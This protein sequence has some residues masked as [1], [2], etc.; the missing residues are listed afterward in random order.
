MKIEQDGD[1]WVV[2]DWCMTPHGWLYAG[3]EWFS[4]KQAAIEFINNC[5]GEEG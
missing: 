3:I 1:M 5:K 2:L 4:S